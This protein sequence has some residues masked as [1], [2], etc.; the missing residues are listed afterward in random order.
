MKTKLLPLFGAAVLLAG[1]VVD[2]EQPF[3]RAADVFFDERLVGEWRAPVQPGEQ[4]GEAIRIERAG[5][6]GYV[7]RHKD[8]EGKELRI[9]LTLFKL[10]G[11]VFA[12][13]REP[14]RDGAPV[15]HQLM[16]VDEL[17]GTWKFRG[18]NY[19]WVRDHLRADPE[20]L[21][22]RFDSAKDKDN[23]PVTL[24]AT[25]AQLQAFVLKHEGEREFFSEPSVLERVKPAPEPKGR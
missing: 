13:F 14:A 11:K 17:G 4:P 25:T 22:H 23:P 6:K 16:R 10:D 8:A 19:R 12:D 5:A 18:V 20:A 3:Y 7:A 24:T 2:S 21:P 9:E 1:C 15:R